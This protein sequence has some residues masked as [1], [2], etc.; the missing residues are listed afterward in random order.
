MKSRLLNPRDLNSKWMNQR[1]VKSEGCW[2][3]DC[4]SQD[5][6]CLYW[7]LCLGID[8]YQNDPTSTSLET[9]DYP[10]WNIDFPGVTICPNTKVSASQNCICICILF[11]FG[12][13]SL[14]PVGSKLLC[15]TPNYPGLTSLKMQPLQVKLRWVFTHINLNTVLPKYFR[16]SCLM[17]CTTSPCSALIQSSWRT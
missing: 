8:R 5:T 3:L 11:I 6:F 15:P 13:F 14:L 9:T 12:I 17:F 7:S 16:K 10:I 1:I 4:W 2:K